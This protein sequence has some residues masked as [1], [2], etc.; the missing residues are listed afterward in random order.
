MDK[1]EQ[2]NLDSFSHRVACPLLGA[3]WSLSAPQGQCETVSA[4]VKLSHNF[5]LFTF[6]IFPHPY[7]FCQASLTRHDISGCPK[8]AV[9]GSCGCEKFICI[10]VE[11]KIVE[12]KSTERYKIQMSCLAQ[13]APESR[14]AGAREGPQGK[15]QTCLLWLYAP[16]STRFWPLLEKVCWAWKIFLLGQDRPILYHEQGP[17][18]F[19]SVLLLQREGISQLPLLIYFI[20]NQIKHFPQYTLALDHQLLVLYNH[21]YLYFPKLL[22]LFHSLFDKIV[23]KRHLKANVLL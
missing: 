21:C 1:T 20:N 2:Q 3:T 17:Q 10:L 8:L 15:H 12:K 16:S 13:A 5:P 11:P 18:H 19:W 7:Y 6:F 23:V 4:T 22:I 9:V 14:M